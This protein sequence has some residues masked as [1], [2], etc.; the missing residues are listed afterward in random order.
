MCSHSL[1][2]DVTGDLPD[3]YAKSEDR[4]T[5]VDVCGGEPSILEEAIC[6]GIAKIRPVEL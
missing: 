3:H 2:D 6:E 1:D 4:L 5:N